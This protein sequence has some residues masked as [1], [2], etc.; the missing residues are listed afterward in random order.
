MPPKGTSTTDSLDPQATMK[1]TAG[2]P[3]ACGGRRGKITPRSA[4]S[5]FARRQ[6]CCFPNSFGGPLAAVLEQLLLWA[7]R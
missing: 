4:A 3:A 6:H 2:K 7:R 1:A 5:T